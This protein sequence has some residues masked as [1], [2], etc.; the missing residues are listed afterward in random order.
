MNLTATVHRSAPVGLLLL[1]L[2]SCDT[3]RST[4]AESSDPAALRSEPTTPVSFRKE[5]NEG[6]HRFVVQ[7]TGQGTQ[8]QLTLR[9]EKSGRDL[10]TNTQVINGAVTD[11]VVTNLNDD[12]F[13]ELL[14]FVSDAGSGSYG[15][16]I[17]Y[18]FQNQ[19]RRPLSMPELSPAAAKGYQGN[20]AFRVEG[21]ELLRSF[22]LYKPEDANCCP[23]GGIRTV[24]YTL[25]NASLAFRQSR[26]ADEAQK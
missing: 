4:T 12:K 13:P 1:A 21:R 18:E 6:D 8:K 9:A 5:L 20:D 17:G 14:L 23:S 3:Q 2:A 26:F 11:A 10:T 22:P 24:R 25:P 19:G 7:T 16:V 15:Q